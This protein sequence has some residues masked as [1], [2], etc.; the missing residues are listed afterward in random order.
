MKKLNLRD[1]FSIDFSKNNSGFFAKRDILDEP[2]M[3]EM[4][5]PKLGKKG[6]EWWRGSGRRRQRAARQ[7]VGAEERL[8]TF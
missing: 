8:N 1:L 5:K 6:G 4:A 3:I 2:P 7:R